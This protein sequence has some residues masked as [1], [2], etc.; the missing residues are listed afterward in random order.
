M[1]LTALVAEDEIMTQKIL[2]VALEQTGFQVTLC[3]DGRECLDN[4]DVGLK[5]DIL[6]LDLEMPIMTG[7]EVM[8]ELNRNGLVESFPIACLTSN[9]QK[10]MVKKALMLGAHDYIVKP[11]EVYGMIFRVLDLIFNVEEKDLRVLIESLHMKDP[12]IFHNAGMQQWAS[13]GFDAYP[14][15]HA[16]KNIC[17]LLP[18][19]AGPAAL[20]RLP[21]PEIV[22]KVHIF[23]KCAFGWRKV[24]PTNSV[25]RSDRKIGA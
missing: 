25:I 16:N 10:E 12:S 3:G 8:E 20:S 11:F 15:V 13:R 1:K 18:H 19:H 5:P 6:I 22:A 24:W 2:S 4:L 23:R 14:T 7:I 9:N 17:V 21:L